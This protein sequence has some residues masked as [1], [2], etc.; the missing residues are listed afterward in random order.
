MDTLY[1]VSMVTIG[2]YLSTIILWNVLKLRLQRKMHRKEKALRKAGI[3]PS[4]MTMRH[5]MVIREGRVENRSSPSLEWY[6][7]LAK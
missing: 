5:G 6:R 3:V 4:G 1:T 2:G 7:R